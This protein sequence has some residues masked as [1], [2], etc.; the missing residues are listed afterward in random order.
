MAGS[1]SEIT[2]TWLWAWANPSFE[3][4]DI[5]EILRVREFGEIHRLQKLI[6]PKWAADEADGWEM[7]AVSARLLRSEAAYRSPSINGCLFILLDRLR[8]EDV[9]DSGATLH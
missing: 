2:D 7:T 3:G 6:N 5:G 8:Y 1:I 9:A 4:C